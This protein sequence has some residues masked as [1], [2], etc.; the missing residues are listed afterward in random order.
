MSS[1]EIGHKSDKPSQELRIV[2]DAVARLANGPRS[3]IVFKHC[4]GKKCL[5]AVGSSL[6]NSTSTGKGEIGKDSRQNSLCLNDRTRTSRGCCL[7][8]E[9][10]RDSMCR[11]SLG[12]SET[13][14]IEP[15][16]KVRSFPVCPMTT[17][18]TMAPK[19]SSPPPPIPP[20]R[21]SFKQRSRRPYPGGS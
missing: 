9:P 10:Y 8:R 21:N 19:A 16:W 17:V 15:L 1:S 7:A 13:A 14:F 20:F 3:G 12:S 11:Q 5:A 4:V 6:F 2:V 18:G